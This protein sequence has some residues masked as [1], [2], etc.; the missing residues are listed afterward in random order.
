LARR[1][2]VRDLMLALRLFVVVMKI[3]RLRAAAT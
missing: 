3:S 2:L 1:L